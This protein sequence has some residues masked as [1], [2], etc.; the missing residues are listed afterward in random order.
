MPRTFAKANFEVSLL[1]PKDSL[2]AK[3]RYVSRR[4]SLPD[5]AVP[6]EFLLALA[7][8][9]EEVKPRLLVPCDEMALRLL[10]ALIPDSREDRQ[11]PAIPSRLAALVRESL[12]DPAFYQTSMDKL[13]LPPAAEALGVRVPRYIIAGSADEAESFA[14]VRGY[15]VVLKRRFGFAGEGVAIVSSADELA[16]EAQLL[17]R[18]VQLDLGERRPPQLLG[19]EFIDGP[20]HSQAIVAW[21]GIPL[22]G[23]SWERHVASLAL[24]GQTTVVRFVRSPESRAFS[25]TLCRAFGISG[26][27][28]QF[29]INA[30]TG[31]AHLLEI[32]RRT[33]THMHMGERVG[34]D[35]AVALHDHL[36]GSPPAPVTEFL[37]D[38]GPTVAVFPREWLRDPESPYLRECPVDVPWDEPELIEAILAMKY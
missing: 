17:M 15:P 26:F 7:S 1:A 24:K 13:L 21:Q 38:F 27:F 36:R 29:I 33:V 31:E 28:A 25:E 9:V 14:A 35:L 3:S 34:A 11:V 22:A 16:R 6:M 32:N 23:F 10:F 4:R 2:A 18:P 12:G 20:Y 19:H 5:K 37:G 8:M 30:D